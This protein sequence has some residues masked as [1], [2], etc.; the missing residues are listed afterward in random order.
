MINCASLATVIPQIEYDL[1]Q[2]QQWLEYLH[3]AH[4]EQHLVALQN[5]L[6][7][8]MGAVELA[9]LSD[10]AMLLGALKDATTH[11]FNEG[12]PWT[13]DLISATAYPLFLVP[14]YC[15]WVVEQ[16]LRN[17]P[18]LLDAINHLRQ[19]SGDKALVESQLLEITIDP[20]ISPLKALK[21]SP[22]AEI[23]APLGKII[24]LFK[25]ARLAIDKQP[26]AALALLA[27]VSQHLQ[28]LCGNAPIGELFWLLSAIIE[29]MQD[30]DL[31]LTKQR[32]QWL[33]LVEQHLFSLYKEPS[34]ALTRPLSLAMKR[35]FLALILLSNSSRERAQKLCK[36]YRLPMLPFSDR[37]IALGI[38]RMRQPGS[39]VYQSLVKSIEVSIEHISLHLAV[40]LENQPLSEESAVL[41]Q[42]H[43]RD[44]HA[45]VTM[46]ELPYTSEL[47]EQCMNDLT[48][49]VETGPQRETL[50]HLAQG[51][52]H[53]PERFKVMADQSLNAEAK[54]HWTQVSD[55]VLMPQRSYSDSVNVVL[56]HAE[57]GISD[58]IL[59][60]EIAHETNNYSV[61]ESLL[62]K[63]AEIQRCLVMINQAELA[64][65]CE[66]I[67]SLLEP[68]SIH[69]DT[70]DIETLS[71]PMIALQQKL[72]ST[73]SHHRIA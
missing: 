62:G 13:D 50:L 54:A 1:A 22:A 48:A 55:I 10:A 8:C 40:L 61:I 16:G 25:K 58:I 7:R 19:Y 65:E 20:R 37:D 17:G 71:W 5:T 44:I 66:S 57:R 52:L 39:D 21:Q 72:Q 51:L 28:K 56:S 43:M 27:K 53:L 45:A 59:Q 73:S 67:Y 29:A 4:D 64:S 11:I 2:A 30:G 34:V 60:L 63:V 3:V 35:E 70:S 31:R 9:G 42:H 6:H 33:L 32:K 47:T 41:I 49:L 23:T 46:C 12:K 69:A 36:L 38:D 18:I 15:R 26:E 24:P 68:C 14:R